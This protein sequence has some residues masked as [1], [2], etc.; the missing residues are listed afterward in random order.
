MFKQSLSF[1]TSRCMQHHRI[2]SLRYQPIIR[3]ISVTR[4]FLFDSYKDV[5]TTTNDRD[6]FNELPDFFEEKDELRIS[7]KRYFES[8][9]VGS[10]YSFPNRATNINLFDIE[11]LILEKSYAAERSYKEIVESNDNLV[12]VVGSIIQYKDP[13]D[14]TIHL[15]VV[16]RNAL[17]KFN[18]F[19]DKLVVLTESNMIDAVYPQDILLHL[20]GVFDPEWVQSLSILENRHD[21][22]YYSRNILVNVLSHLINKSNEYQSLILNPKDFLKISYAKMCEEELSVL[23][24]W[25]LMNSLE[26]D[27]SVWDQVNKNYFTQCCFLLGTYNAISSHHDMFLLPNMFPHL[28]ITNIFHGFSNNL[29]KPSCVY[30]LPQASFASFRE[31]DKILDFEPSFKD[32]NNFLNTFTNQ[33]NSSAR[34]ELSELH[35]FFNI[36]EGKAYTAV[37]D[38]IKFVTIFPHETII[39]K[40]EKFDIFK[41]DTSS[42]KFLEYLR[43]MG[44]Y[45]DSTDI[46]LSLGFWGQSNITKKVSFEKEEPLTLKLNPES[47]PAKKEFNFLR[48]KELGS[49]DMIYALHIDATLKV[50]ISLQK[51]NSRNFLINIHIPDMIT[52]VSPKSKLFQEMLIKCHKKLLTVL[53]YNSSKLFGQE[54]NNMFDMKEQFIDDQFKDF[55]PVGD[56]API[57]SKPTNAMTDTSC[58]TLS[59]KYNIFESNPFKDFKDKVTYSLMDIS[60]VPIKVLDKK[61]LSESL[62]HKGSSLPFALFRSKPTMEIPRLSK[63]DYHNLGFIYNVLRAHFMVRNIDGATN[64]QLGDTFKKEEFFVKELDMLASNLTSYYCTVGEIPIILKT[65]SIIEEVN[66]NQAQSDKVLIKHNNLL[67]PE[68]HAN[69]YYQTLISRDINGNVSLPAYIIGNNYLAPP[70]LSLDNVRDVPSALKLGYLSIL[71]PADNFEALFNQFQIVSS[72]HSQF[73]AKTLVKSGISQYKFQKRFAYLKGLGYNVNGPWPNRIVQKHITSLKNAQTVN[74]FAYNLVHK[75]WAIKNLEHELSQLN[76]DSKLDFECIITNTGYTFPDHK[77]KMAKCYVKTMKIECDILVNDSK[78]LSIGNVFKSNKVLYL[79]PSTLTC[80]LGESEDY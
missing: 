62:D 43:S 38:M 66:I 5:D 32:C 45:S 23:E 17:S 68:F 58:L 59:F 48:Q 3:H 46:F 80:V 35:L 10:A 13:I 7:V 9:R 21:I 63:N 57:R 73:M 49:N 75:Y 28:S 6:L 52:R 2:K 65:Q 34:K 74:K 47:L 4:P 61:L 11:H 29:T 16:L 60:N 77:Y 31:F 71:N 41:N 56:I 26:L 27:E 69:S 67:L 20:H 55:I 50:G 79:N 15:G 54:M 39:T 76:T 19:Y 25:Q 1:Y 53:P 24:L 78:N 33:Q 30:I 51:L 72:L 70:K 40:L 42:T 36:W 12:P 14:Q 64:I 18:D 8:M 22:S 44:L 37:L